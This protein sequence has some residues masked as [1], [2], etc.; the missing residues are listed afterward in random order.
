MGFGKSCMFLWS[1]IGL[2]SW[3]GWSPG[4]YEVQSR[5]FSTL[6]DGTIFKYSSK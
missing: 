1:L 5:E 2:V 3:N 6:L 4:G